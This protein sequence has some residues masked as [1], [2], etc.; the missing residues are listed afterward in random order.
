MKRN[1]GFTLIELLAVIA[2]LGVLLS[3]STVAVVSIKNKQDDKNRI[4]VISGILTGAKAYVAE[5]PS[6]ISKISED[7]IR[8]SEIIEKGFTTFDTNKFSELSKG[9]VTITECKE[10]K[11]KLKY[12]IKV[13]NDTYND[14]GCESQTDSAEEIC[15]D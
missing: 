7:G 13:G 3:I 10:N 11:L 15:T 5:N 14:C 12:G 6:V 9:S 4:N 1:K 2:I 8:V